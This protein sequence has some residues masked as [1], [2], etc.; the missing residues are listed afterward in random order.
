MKRLIPTLI[1]GLSIGYF[2]G[3]SHSDRN[4]AKVLQAQW[5][6]ETKRM[7]YAYS[8]IDV[9]SSDQCLEAWSELIEN[10]KAK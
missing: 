7:E 3:F 5:Q 8:M 2:A 10:V 9:C 4:A 1:I 6:G